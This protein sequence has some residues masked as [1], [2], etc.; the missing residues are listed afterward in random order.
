MLNFLSSTERNF[1]Q[2]IIVKHKSKVEIELFSLFFEPFKAN[3][4][5]M[6]MTGAA[7][8]AKKAKSLGLV[9]QTV[10]PLGPGKISSVQYLE[11]VSV[12]YAKQVA[13]G[14]LKRKIKKDAFPTKVCTK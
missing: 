10:E 9:D 5:P 3:A 2:L 7:K 12:N 13:S 6:L 4:F 14:Q 1:G 8:P 11:E